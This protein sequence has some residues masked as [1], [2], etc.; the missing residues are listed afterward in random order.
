MGQP[1]NTLEGI[2]KIISQCQFRDWDLAI[3]TDGTDEQAFPYLQ[4]QFVAPD[5]FTGIAEKQY[6]RKWKLSYYM[7]DSELVSTA[8]EAVRRAME[9]EVREDFRF[10]GEPVFRPHFDVYALHEISKSNR[11]DRRG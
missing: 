6:C 2:R 11:V 10:N 4:V 3:H 8:F 1:R 7:T 5:S 9:H